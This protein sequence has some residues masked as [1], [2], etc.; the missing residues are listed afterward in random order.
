MLKFIGT[1]SAFNS[2]LGNNCAYIRKGKALI[3]FDCGG[4]VFN[5]LKNSNLL[6]DI[7]EVFVFI[8]H[9]HGDHVGSLPTL[10]EYGY[11]VA[12][13]NTVVIHPDRY[14][15]EM[16]QFMGVKGTM[17]TYTDRPKLI[18]SK[19]FGGGIS[20]DHVTTQHVKEIS[21]Y[22][23]VVSITGKTFYYSGDSRAIPQY[24]LS[25]FMEGRIEHLYQDT[26]ETDFP[27][28]P[29]LPL[30]TLNG[31]IPEEHRSR[32]TCMHLTPGFSL[33][34]IENAGFKVANIDY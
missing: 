8:T 24:V 1:G 18:L 2:V 16:L 30:E 14:I 29:H 32:V 22:G 7:E 3:L 17:Y 28:N 27:N 19:N 12:K 5:K 33:K 13:Y 34:A 15:V 10:I 31:V 6:D 11:Y 4:D 25:H 20:F 23:Y 9:L 21:S 26:C